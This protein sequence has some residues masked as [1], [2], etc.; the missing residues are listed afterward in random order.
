[1]ETYAD[2]AAAR[3]GDSLATARTLQAAVDAVL[4]EPSAEGMQAAKDAWL[5]AR[6]P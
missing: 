1:M 4:A 6:V 2:I 3:Y 5:A